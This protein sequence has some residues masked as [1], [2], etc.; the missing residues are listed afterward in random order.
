MHRQIK[1][2][3]T[4]DK[5]LTKDSLLPDST[6][7]PHR[8]GLTRQSSAGLTS[9]P[10]SSRTDQVSRR[11]P[12]MSPCSRD[13]E[14]N[15]TKN[16]KYV[17]MVQKNT[18]NVTKNTKCPN[19]KFVETCK[20]LDETDTASTLQTVRSVECDKQQQPFVTSDGSS[21]ATEIE[22]EEAETEYQKW[23]GI[24]CSICTEG[25]SKQAA[26]FQ[27]Q[28]NR[29]NKCVCGQ[30]IQLK[31]VDVGTS[32]AQWQWICRKCANPR[33]SSGV[34]VAIPERPLSDYIF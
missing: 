9:I 26:R 8:G 34:P 21:D 30:C 23:L 20:L 19:S 18:K 22:T 1:S 15:V 25:F 28:C 5:V 16:T 4:A 31:S 33:E 10:R 11:T 6:L 14:K 2:V 12:R 13:V 17:T 7:I 29:C 27:H 3:T 32:V 24:R